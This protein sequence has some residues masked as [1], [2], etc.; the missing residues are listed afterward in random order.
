MSNSTD[1]DTRDPDDDLK[2]SNTEDAEAKAISF[3]FIASS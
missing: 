1:G 3:S 2:K